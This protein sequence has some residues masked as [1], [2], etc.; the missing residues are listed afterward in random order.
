MVNHDSAVVNA[1]NHL[2]AV[3]RFPQSGERQRS[4]DDTCVDLMAPF[5]CLRER[6]VSVRIAHPRYLRRQ[7]YVLPGPLDADLLVQKTVIKSLGVD[8]AFF[9]ASGS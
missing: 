7:K 5:F 3:E 1:K 6:F 9:F 8:P 4:F 2:C